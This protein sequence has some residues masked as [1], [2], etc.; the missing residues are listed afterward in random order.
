MTAENGIHLLS[1]SLTLTTLRS[2]MKPFPEYGFLKLYFLPRNSFLLYS[3]RIQVIPGKR[4]MRSFT[5]KLSHGPIRHWIWLQVSYHCPGIVRV[6][7]GQVFLPDPQMILFPSQS[8]FFPTYFR[9]GNHMF[10]IA[11][12]I[13]VYALSPNSTPFHFHKGPGLDN[14]L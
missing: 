6:H 7:Q 5:L 13:T 9:W 14:E 2:I 3:N 11:Q 8:L 12:D 10:Q 4:T 1:Q